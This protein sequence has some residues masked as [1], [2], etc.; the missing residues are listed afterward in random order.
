M[1]EEYRAFKRYKEESRPGEAKLPEG[2]KA[3][4]AVVEAVDTTMLSKEQ[5]THTEAEAVGGRRRYRLCR[6]RTQQPTCQGG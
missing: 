4:V 1:V 2:V 6:C 3:A 5:L